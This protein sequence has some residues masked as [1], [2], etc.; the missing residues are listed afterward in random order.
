MTLLKWKRDTVEE[1]KQRQRR[2]SNKLAGGSE[3]T[4]PQK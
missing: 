2:I 1:A 3:F 4:K